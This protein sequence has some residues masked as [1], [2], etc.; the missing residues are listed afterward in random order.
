[1]NVTGHIAKPREVDA[2]AFNAKKG[3]RLRFVAEARA[4]GSPLDPV[5]RL[6]DAKGTVVATAET[7]SST[8]IDETLTATIKADGQYRLEMRDLHRRGGWRYF[9]RL[10]MA[11]DPLVASA[12][13]AGETFTLGP[14]K[15]LKIPVTITGRA[16]DAKELKVTVDG[17]PKTVSVKLG[18]LR[19]SR[20][21]RVVDVVLTT[22]AKSPHAGTIRITLAGKDGSQ[23]ARATIP[24]TGLT[25]RELWLTV[26]K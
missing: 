14:K 7:R 5:L 8:A 10:S 25:T 11:R 2:Y 26:T 21:S 9:Y 19:R 24:G 13:V 17:L 18:K 6:T 4:I 22:K 23:T 12:T 20:R 1:M 16:R 15:A 3:D